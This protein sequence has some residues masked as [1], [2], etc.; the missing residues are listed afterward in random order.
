MAYIGLLDLL[1]SMPRI[2]VLN[3]WTTSCPQ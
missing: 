1:N 3:K 2:I